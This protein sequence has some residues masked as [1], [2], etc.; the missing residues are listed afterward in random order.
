MVSHDSKHR[1]RSGPY[2]CA[3]RAETRESETEHLEAAFTIK[4]VADLGTHM[5]FLRVQAATKLTE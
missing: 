3:G 1:T 4:T 2:S 5:F